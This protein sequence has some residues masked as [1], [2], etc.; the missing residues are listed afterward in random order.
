MVPGTST[1]VRLAA[2][3]PLPVGSTVDATDG[4]VEIS[5]EAGPD[6][7]EQN[8][9]VTGGIFKIAQ[10]AGK[11]GLTDLVLKGGDFT[12]CRQVTARAAGKGKGDVARGI[13]AAGKGRFRTKGRH[14]AAT[15]RG[16]RWSVVDRCHSTTVK[17]FEG[18][19]DVND[20]GLG[21]T[22]QVR[23]GERHVAREPR[24]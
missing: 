16:T 24:G 7:A 5:S 13:W 2:D 17:V 18:I 10:D 4:L 21:R 20:F 12:D 22:V 9:V 14:S 15:V 23:G 6:G 19:V 1:F 3:A 11:A 8:A